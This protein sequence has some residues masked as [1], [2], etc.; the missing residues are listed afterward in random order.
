MVINVLKYLIVGNSNKQIINNFIT[1]KYP[2]SMKILTSFFLILL[3]TS[4]IFA[5]SKENKCDE[6]CIESKQ[7]FNRLIATQFSKIMTGNS[8][9]NFGRFVTVSTEDKTLSV[10]GVILDSLNTNK[11]WTYNLSGGISDGITSVFND[12]ELN[13]N[14]GASVVLHYIIN[15]FKS[16]RITIDEA[17]Y[18][19]IEK[20][21]ELLRLKFISDSIEIASKKERIDLKY[22][23]MKLLKNEKILDSLHK[24]YVNQKGSLRK[25]SIY[26]AFQI[27]KHNKKVLVEKLKK[28]T[29][30]E[31][32][33]KL[34]NLYQKFDEDSI[35]LENKRGSAVVEDLDLTWFSIGYGIRRDK[36]NLFDSSLVFD[37]Q[38][39]D[40]T[41]LSHKI[42]IGLSRYRWGHAS[43][44]DLFWSLSTDFEYGSN[45]TSLTGI[46]IFDSSLISINPQRE[47][48]KKTSAF[49]DEFKKDIKRVTLRFDY[50]TFVGRKNEFALH[51][52][53]AIEIADFEKPNTSFLTGV[54]IPFKNTKKQT[55][56]VNLEVFYQLNDIFDVS[57]S[58]NIFFKRNTIGV[59]A[60]FPF[61]F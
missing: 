29:D 36:F 8:F 4:N 53:P 40:S 1:I 56:A 37:E 26:A 38:V 18:K 39:K 43:K 23:K 25:D 30:K 2:F 16:N 42:N 11:V 45:L 47:L 55:S 44:N 22:Q 5:Q 19:K 33:N 9:S 49:V 32:D 46:E 51:F 7:I 15:P 52:K 20:S 12:F 3:L 48:I 60:T 27:L 50:Y 21:K 57:N 59:Q 13:S 24:M 10:S 28:L 54:L 61:I 35:A 41:T 31:F 34:F 6:K 14:I 58:N 17:E